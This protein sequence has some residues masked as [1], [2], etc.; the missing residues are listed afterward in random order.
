MRILFFLILATN[1]Y[2]QK[3]QVFH[4]NFKGKNDL[5]G[6]CKF[7]KSP[8]F[9]KNALNSLNK[10]IRPIGLPANFILVPCPNIENALAITS[11]EGLRYIVYDEN[12]INSIN[13]AENNWIS[14]SILAHEVGHHLSGHTLKTANSL[15]DNRK[16]ELEADEFS[17]FIL[18]KL[19]ANLDQSQQ[20]INTFIIDY[21]D[22]FSTH[23]TKNKRLTAI[24]KGFDNAASLVLQETTNTVEY[25]FNIALEKSNSL[26]Y[27][28]A[29]EAYTKAI[30]INNNTASLYSNRS[31]AKLNLGYFQSAYDDAYKAMEIEPKDLNAIVYCGYINHHYLKKY[32]KAIEFYDYGIKAFEEFG[33]IYQERKDIGDFYL[34]RANSYSIL[35]NYDKAMIDYN[36]AITINSSVKEYYNGRGMLYL[37]LENYSLAIN[38]FHEAI[39]LNSNYVN[40]LLGRAISYKS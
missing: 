11:S 21:D 16:Q 36:K 15:E 12:F 9:D 28:G 25:Y 6:I 34:N 30:E 5:L 33:D 40:A 38:D 14:I 13:S 20:A 35:E 37:S 17:G 32:E 10:I 2:A 26:D 7:Q 31:N 27:T 39:K 3:T 29:I 22:K 18:K 23:P 8:T 1:I 24:K 4:C 19:G